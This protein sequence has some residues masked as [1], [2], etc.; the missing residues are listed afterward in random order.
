MKK[1]NNKMNQIIPLLKNASPRKHYKLF[2]EF[3]DGINGIIDLSAWK[4]KSAF[5][6]WNDENNFKKFK[7]TEDRK[8]EWSDKIDMDPDAFY[9]KLT[10]KTFDEYAGDK[11]LL[12]NYN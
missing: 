12:R 1:K 3:E 7:I 9:L 8:L 5:A 11:Q 2:V 4:E 10:G 6:F